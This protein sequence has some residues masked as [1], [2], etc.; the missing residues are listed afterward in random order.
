MKRALLIAALLLSGC[1]TLQTPQ[2]SVGCQ[3][4]DVAT[5]AIA[6]HAGAVEMN[7][8]AHALIGSVGWPGFLAV[9]IGVGLWLAHEAKKAPTV[10]AVA[11]M[12]TCAVAVHNLLVR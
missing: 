12:A 1:A 5:T 7:P 10:V 6:L 8:V 11:N 3:V 4:A 9:K 2:A